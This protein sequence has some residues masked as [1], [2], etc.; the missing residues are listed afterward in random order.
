MLVRMADF[1]PEFA[2]DVHAGIDTES[3]A[4][5]CKASR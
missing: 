2:H 1:R 3:D 4:S 5:G